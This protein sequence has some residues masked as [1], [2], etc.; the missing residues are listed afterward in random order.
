MKPRRASGTS[1]LT[2][3][4][5]R[6]RRWVLHT[7]RTGIEWECQICSAT[8]SDP[9]KGESH[10]KAATHYRACHSTQESRA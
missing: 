8:G 10:A 1:T 4:P 2:A 6:A 3:K 5:R 7:T 9:D